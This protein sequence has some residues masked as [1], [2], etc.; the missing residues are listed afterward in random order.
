MLV[1]VTSDST[2]DLSADIIERLDIGIVPLSVT[3]GESSFKDGTEMNVED[4]YEYVDHIGNLPKTS[5]VNIEDYMETFQRYV[6]EGYEIVHIN[7]SAEFS[8][9]YQNACIAAQEVGHVHV[10]DSR[11]LSTGQGLIVMKAAE[12]AAEGKR[13][14][15]IYQECLDMTARVE[16]SFVIDSLDY[17]YKGGRCSGLAAFGANVLKLKPSIVVK[18]GIMTPEK[19]Y[20]GAFDNVILRY[21]QD[22]LKDRDDID[23]SRIFLTHT[24]CTEECINGVRAAI[25][26][27]APEFKEIIETTA[28]STITTHCGPNTLGI[29]FVRKK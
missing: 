28:G 5:A 10:V 2:C 27:F 15:E 11:N 21:V 4:I 26:K 20:R 8:C 6:D 17:L 13:A 1:K 19:K 23:Y 9:T 29:L 7:L 18:D 3:L 24:R 22:H 16:A 14:E 25:M 12:M